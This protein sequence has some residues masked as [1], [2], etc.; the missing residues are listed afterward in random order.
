MY[1]EFYIASL[2]KEFLISS[3]IALLHLV[4]CNS[5][6]GE[7]IGGGIKRDNYITVPVN[8]PHD[9]S[10]RYSTLSLAFNISILELRPFN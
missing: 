7:R 4:H 2:C 6:G 5:G 1:S 10:V 9:D 8:V 3:F